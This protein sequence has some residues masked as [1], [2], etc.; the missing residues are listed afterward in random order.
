MA[1]WLSVL[2]AVLPYLAPIV[3]AA[4]PAFTWKRSNA[5]SDPL[6]SQQ[7]DELQEAVKAN[8]QCVKIIAEQMQRMIQAMEDAAA[9]H[10]KALKSARRIAMVWFFVA[11]ASLGVAIV[12]VWVR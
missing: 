3:S 7:I 11:F 10:E 5:K 9:S 8:A 1:A 4:V 12:T 6:V 2:K